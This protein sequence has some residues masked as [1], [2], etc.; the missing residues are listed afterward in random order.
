MQE[1]KSTDYAQPRSSQSHPGPCV[2]CCTKNPLRIKYT[3]VHLAEDGEV[4]QKACYVP[5]Q[6]RKQSTHANDCTM[7]PTT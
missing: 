7:Q 2:L 4:P 1:P 6:P 5:L 3:R